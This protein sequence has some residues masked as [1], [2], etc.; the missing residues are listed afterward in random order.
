MAGGLARGVCDAGGGVLTGV[1]F[2][3]IFWSGI[4]NVSTHLADGV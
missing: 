3:G 1:L 2:D 4:S